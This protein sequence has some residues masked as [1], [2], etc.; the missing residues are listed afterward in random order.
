MSTDSGSG[1]STEVRLTLFHVFFPLCVVWTWIGGVLKVLRCAMKS[2]DS[3]FVNKLR[4]R[5]RNGGKKPRTRL[6]GVNNFLSGGSLGGGVGFYY[7]Y[8]FL[9]LR[10]LPWT[11]LNQQ[12]AP[13][14]PIITSTDWQRVSGARGARCHCLCRVW[15]HCINLLGSRCL[16]AREVRV[17]LPVWPTRGVQVPT[18][19][20]QDH[21]DNPWR[22]S[23]PAPTGSVS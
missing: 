22:L 19:L 17:Y 14:G 11:V 16:S 1:R 6:R 7:Y 12:A 23:Q 3:A 18:Q 21:E 5:H 4:V 15:L 8:F 20:K 10:L 2:L 13:P 9:F